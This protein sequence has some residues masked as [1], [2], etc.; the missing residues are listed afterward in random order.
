MQK[1]D[2]CVGIS[3]PIEMKW[4]HLAEEYVSLYA[5]TVGFNERLTAMMR[6]SVNEA[7]GELFKRA[8]DVGKE[9]M[10]QVT[11][12]S[13]KY[14]MDILITYD[15][16]IPLN[17]TKEKP[18]EVPSDRVDIQTVDTDSLWL[19]LIKY[20]MDRVYF[21]KNGKKQNLHIIK[22][23]REEGKERQVWVL[24]QKPVLK[25]GTNIDIATH[26]D[27]K[28]AGFVQNFNTG[29][30]LRLGQVE[31]HAVQHFDGCTSVYDIY[32]DA[33]GRGW[34]V[35]PS[36]YVNLY[37]MLE[38]SH[39]LQKEGVQHSRWYS[40]R[41]R[42]NNM[43]YS[44]PHSD[45]LVGTFYQIFKP[46]FTRLAMWCIILLS[47]SAIYPII[48]AHHEIKPLLSTSYNLMKE[49]WWV[50]FFFFLFN[51]MTIFVHEMSHGAACK[52][53]GGTVSHV[54]ISYYLTSF[55]FFCD[56]T[57]SYNFSQKM[58]RIVVSIAGPLSTLL[59]W[60]I[61]CWGFYLLDDLPWKLLCMALFISYSFGLLMN[62][63]PF[64][65][66]DAYYVVA[67]LLGISN[68]RWLS[69][70]LIKNK[71]KS[72]MGIYVPELYCPNEK[73]L[74][75]WAY[76][77][78]GSLVTVLF[79]VMPF[80]RFISYVSDGLHLSAQIFWITFLL[81]LTCFNLINWVIY[82]INSIRNQEFNLK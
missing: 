46:M 33:V 63:N 28:Y 70:S 79:C 24:G 56:I 38:E 2:N 29:L 52:K 10:V 60:S 40:L 78:V 61:T 8:A 31:M 42:I 54:G 6:Q 18:F 71:F 22:Y 43:S 51:S 34:L 15:G 81:L 62:L 57:T 5:T 19:Y 17:P 41:Q 49:N 16:D 55:I 68:L 37:V 47:L 53:Y 77:I 67:D 82:S 26:P 36:V 66:M 13:D 59:F 48:Q 69:F 75:I 35:E 23:H 20:R 39:M 65:K 72:W 3:I 4:L 58:Q 30:V 25:K 21:R 27:A 11:I 12:Y 44:F 9:G 14:A 76:G 64:I 73:Q 45:K 74:W 32:L 50:L 1:L 80:I 7:C